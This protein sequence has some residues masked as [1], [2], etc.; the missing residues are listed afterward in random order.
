MKNIKTFSLTFMFLILTGLLLTYPLESLAFSLTGL[1]LWFNKMVPALLP[2][3]ILSG[4]MVRL[5]LT[6]YFAKAASPLLTPLL[7]ISLNGVYAIVIGFLCGFPMGARTI[8][9]LYSCGKLTKKEASFLLAFCNNIGPVYFISFV[10]PTLGLQRKAPYLFGMYG[11]PLLYGI[12]LRYTLY[13]KEIT[14]SKPAKKIYRQ[15]FLH[16]SDD[17][18]SYKIKNMANRH[19]ARSRLHPGKIIGGETLSAAEYP[20]AGAARPISLPDTLDDA[21]LSGLYSISK[22][23][24][25]MVLFNLL[26]LVPQIFLRPIPIAGTDSASLINC[27]LEITSGISRVG[28]AAPL[29]VLLLLPFG[30]FSCIAQTYSM[31]KETDLPLQSYILHK[32]ALTAATAMYYGLFALLSPSA[33]LL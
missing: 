19:F 15:P 24:G 32:L 10:L 12:L 20:S 9:E 18:I 21:I 27:L 30:G 22:L 13:K 23:G 16:A 1:Q 17:A 14:Y 7:H 31:I 3:M 29:P 8:A 4:M 26:N 5:S 11:L 28:N 25:Y 33:F 2:F 6:E